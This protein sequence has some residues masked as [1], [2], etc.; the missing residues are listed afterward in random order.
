[1]QKPWLKSYPPDVPA[2]VN[3]AQYSS[4]VELPELSYEKYAERD[5]AI[6]M[7]S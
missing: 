4:L 5:A 6:C 3:V 7:G 2:E 1:M